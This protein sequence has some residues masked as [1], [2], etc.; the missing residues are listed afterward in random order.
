MQKQAFS[1]RMVH[2]LTR[3]GISTVMD[4][5][6]MDLTK[7]VCTRNIGKKS[8][9]E[10][11]ERLRSRIKYEL[12]KQETEIR[13]VKKISW[14]LKKEDDL[15]PD[16]LD[17]ALEEAIK[18]AIEKACELTDD[19]IEKLPDNP[20]IMSQIMMN[21]LLLLWL[22]N[23][24]ESIILDHDGISRKRLEKEVPSWLVSYGT[25][26]A[27]LDELVEQLKIEAID[28]RY[29]WRLPD[30]SEWIDSLKDNER[31]ALTLKLQKKTLRECGEVLGVSRERVHQ[32]IQSALKKK[33]FLREDEYGYCFR[34][35]DLSEDF[36]TFV[37]DM[38]PFAYAYLNMM[39]GKRFS[40]R[41]RY[42][43]ISE[44]EWDP[45]FKN[46]SVLT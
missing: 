9:Q 34:K 15:T 42:A 6:K 16:G 19:A 4:F 41:Q 32:I 11:F 38:H 30:L 36:C 1:N 43:S 3:Q 18:N 23:Y 24:L 27:A 33:P 20:T 35:Y 25:F 17:K 40:Q 7:L 12:G 46:Q 8:I 45:L 14:R 21:Q 13:A 28:D 37:F 5:V 31:K 10:A 29:R 22:E 39:R 2:Y 26:D 44:Y